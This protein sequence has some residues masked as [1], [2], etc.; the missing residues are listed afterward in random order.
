MGFFDEVQLSQFATSIPVRT[1]TLA[2]YKEFALYC[3]LQGQPGSVVYM[4]IYFNQYSGAQEKLVI[5]PGGIS[6]WAKV[7][8]V[9]APNVGVVLYN[10]SAPMQGLIR[11]Y[12]ACCPEPPSLLLRG[13][14]FL[15]PRQQARKIS[16]EVPGFDPQSFRPLSST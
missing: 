13:I 4:E 14:R 15:R 2:G 3:W 16:D 5:T 8:S 12:A 7:Y 9:F 10:P 11:V 6:I 1:W